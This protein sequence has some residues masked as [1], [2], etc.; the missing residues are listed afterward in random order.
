MY[1]RSVAHES[2]RQRM[3]LPY[4]KTCQV[5]CALYAYTLR[6]VDSCRLG[7]KTANGGQSGGRP[8]LPVDRVAGRE[9]PEN[10]KSAPTPPGWD[11]FEGIEA[12]SD[13]LI[14][15]STSISRIDGHR[16]R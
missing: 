8:P 5:A 10:P 6:V 12:L 14:N 9:I 11:A 15:A 16:G 7:M 1:D 2:R 3:N 4:R 13:A